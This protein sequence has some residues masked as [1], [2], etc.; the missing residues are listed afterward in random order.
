[1]KSPQIQ[2]GNGVRQIDSRRFLPRFHNQGRGHYVLVVR[3]RP[4]DNRGRRGQAFAQFGHQLV[5]DASFSRIQE[6]HE[7]SHPLRAS[8]WKRYVRVPHIVQRRDCDLPHTRTTRVGFVSGCDGDV[9][10]LVEWYGGPWSRVLRHIGD[11]E[12]VEV[13]RGI[14]RTRKRGIRVTASFGFERANKVGTTKRKVR[15]SSRR[16]LARCF[17]DPVHCGRY[18]CIDRWKD[19]LAANACPPISNVVRLIATCTTA[20]SLAVRTRRIRRTHNTNERSVA[21]KDG[22]TPVDCTER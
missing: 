19:R 8:S 10:G 11:R 5:H 17:L 13:L 3:Q 2:K 15:A 14:G 16:Q 1:M 18:A 9:G 7:G 22:S 6:G 20:R 4:G 21:I 12:V